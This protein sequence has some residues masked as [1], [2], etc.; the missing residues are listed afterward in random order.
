MCQKG[1]KISI[2]F[3]QRLKKSVVKGIKIF[4]KKK[5]NKKQQYGCEDY[6]NLSEDEKQKL[7]EYRKKISLNTK[8]LKFF[9]KHLEWYLS[10]Q[11][12]EESIRNLVGLI[13]G[14]FRRT[15]FVFFFWEGVNNF[16]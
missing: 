2:F 10:Y 15:P 11:F 7:V 8:K 9:Y 6:K 13:I 12:F 14:S 4:Q 16:G 5:K 3:S 1:Y